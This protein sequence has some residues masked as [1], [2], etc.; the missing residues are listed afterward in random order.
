MFVLS[1][2]LTIGGKNYPA[3]K[4]VTID[5]C[6]K[7]ISDT[8]EIELPKY[9]NLKRPDLE[10]AAIKFESGYTQYG[11]FT[12]FE[13]FVREVSENQP[14][15][16][17]C[18]D[19]F[20]SLRNIVNKTYKNIYSGAII[21]QLCNGT[22][23]DTSQV[24]N[25]VKI[26]YKIYSNKT[27]RF[28][29]QDL[30][31]RSGYDCFMR[32]NKIVFGPPFKDADS[33]LVGIFRYGQNIIEDNL[34]LS[35]GDF[36][37]VTVVSEKMDGTGEIFKGVAGTGKKNKTVYIDNLSK[38]DTI[39]RAK[40]M[41]KFL[42]YKGFRGDIQA[43]GYPPAFHSGKIRVIDDRFPDK[44]GYYYTEKVEKEYGDSGFRQKIYLFYGKKTAQ[45]AEKNKTT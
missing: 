10:G 14:Y 6:R 35:D 41:L 38:E 20:Y 28:I 37:K 39:E 5:S 45:W 3:V 31:Y 9:K 18:E 12:E 26:Q 44:S 4:K 29:L 33:G 16:L 15:T 36:D 11:L 34:S 22:G 40:E 30:A 23:I 8:A 1:H 17:T 19:Y 43:F 42:N 2:R 24:Q 27:A 7:A 21:K 13:G 25:G 32:G